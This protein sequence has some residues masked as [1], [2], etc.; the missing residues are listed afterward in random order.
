MTLVIEKHNAVNDTLTAK[1]EIDK[2]SSVYG[3]IICQY[4][5]SDPDIAY[6]V[7]KVY[8][9][10]VKAAQQAL[11]RYGNRYGITWTKQ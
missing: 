8:Y 4:S 2:F 7:H 10:T 1:I 3:L 5:L 11:K 9:S 6:P